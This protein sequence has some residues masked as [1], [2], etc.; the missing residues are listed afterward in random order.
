MKMR[1][2]FTAFKARMALLTSEQQLV[3]FELI[4]DRGMPYPAEALFGRFLGDEGLNHASNVA[5]PDFPTTFKAGQVW[6][7]D[8]FG[9]LNASGG[10]L[11]LSAHIQYK[12]LAHSCDIDRTALDNLH[13][14]SFLPQPFYFDSIINTIVSGGGATEVVTIHAR[15][16]L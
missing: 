2:T 13:H 16:I 3:E 11:T 7:L 8:Q 12:G 10:A 1:E 6:V 14:E 4:R 5:S 15:R 9:V